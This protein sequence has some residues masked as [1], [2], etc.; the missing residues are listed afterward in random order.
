MRKINWR[1]ALERQNKGNGHKAARN[2][3]RGKG[4]WRKAKH[5]AYRRMTEQTELTEKHKTELKYTILRKE[6][7]A[8]SQRIEEGE[9]M[10]LL[11]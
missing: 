7:R 1:K 9:K 8:N 6:E 4:W 11:S 2:I 5:G 10:K 3:T